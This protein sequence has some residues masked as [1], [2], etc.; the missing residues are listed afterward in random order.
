MPQMPKELIG[1]IFAAAKKMSR[2]MLKAL[3]VKGTSI[4][5]ANGAVAG[6]KAPHFMVHVMPRK[7]GDLMFEIPKNSADEADLDKVMEKLRKYLGYKQEQEFKQDGL[8]KQ[9]ESPDNP[10]SQEGH[11][12]NEGDADSP[13]KNP[14]KEEIKKTE[15]EIG[16]EKAEEK[17]GKEKGSGKELKVAETNSQEKQKDLG[18]NDDEP[19]N[20]DDI[21]NMFL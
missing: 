8:K 3:H 11:E 9:P 12:S 18:P 19:I 1:R 13:K 6:Q 2:A 14:E 20:I 7:Q 10:D 5:V 16:K 17:E 4:F 21:A 15:K